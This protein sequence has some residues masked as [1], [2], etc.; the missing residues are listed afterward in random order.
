MSAL[1]WI[2][3]STSLISLISLIGIFALS[4]KEKLLDRILMLLVA[5]SAGALM[6]G[7][8]LH[9]MP[10]AVGVCSDAG[11]DTMFANVIF[12][13]VIFFVMEKILFWRHCHDADCEVHSFG[14]MNLVGD[15][16]HNF[17]DGLVLAAAFLSSIQLG[18]ATTLAI[19]FHEIP[20][21]IGDFG[22]L[23]HSG[24][25]KKRAI[26][27]NFGTAL[28]AIV[29][30]VVGFFVSS[31]ITNFEQMLL[32]IAAGGFIY[33]ASSDLIPELRKIDDPKK[34]VST[35]A[36]FLFGIFLMWIAKAVFV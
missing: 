6:G 21:E 27:L 4:L 3:I 34:S 17:I 25:K 19:A 16:V 33:I 18:M 5:L 15:V 35:F 14:Y 2:L 9:L 10:E 31:G 7:A 8:F 11:L 28:S 12:G 24:M 20:Q 13:F 26:L 36:V 30:G 23:L 22:V 1:V 32:P 29:G